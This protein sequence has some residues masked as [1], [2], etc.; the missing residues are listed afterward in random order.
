[1]IVIS[2]RLLL[3]RVQLIGFATITDPFFALYHSLRQR[4]LGDVGVEGRFGK[5]DVQLHHFK[6]NV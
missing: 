1:M 4:V 6:I 3:E 5:E 2:S